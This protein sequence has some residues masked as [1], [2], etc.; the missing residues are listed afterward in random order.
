MTVQSNPPSPS[1]PVVRADERLERLFDLMD[2][3]CDSGVAPDV[4][5]VITFVETHGP[6]IRTLLDALIAEDAEDLP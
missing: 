6:V 2:M 5:A 3:A 1:S 4:L